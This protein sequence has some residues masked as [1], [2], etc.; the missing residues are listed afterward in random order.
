MV[1]G[2]LSQIGDTATK[3]IEKT[4]SLPDDLKYH[5][6]GAVMASHLIGS[7]GQFLGNFMTQCVVYDALLGRKYTLDDLKNS[8]DIW[9]LATENPSPARCFTYKAPGKG[10]T[11]QIMT[12]RQGAALL[13]PLL[14]Q[15]VENAFQLFEGTLLGK[16]REETTLP[17]IQLKR[18]LPIALGTM[19]GMAGTA[20]SAMLQQM[21]IPSVTGAIRDRA[22]EFAVNRGSLQQRATQETL[23]GVA[24]QKLIAMKNVL[25][26]LIY[27]AFIFILPMAMLPLGW[28]FIRTWVSL[29][30]WIQLWPPLYAIL[31]FI[32]TLAAQ[33]KSTALVQ[34]A[35]GI[36]QSDGSTGRTTTPEGHLVNVSNSQLRS[37]LQLS[38]SLSQNDRQQASKA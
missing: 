7:M 9:K 23:A 34:T 8:S 24:A 31:N 13:T 1:A 3:E 26:A 19:T 21:L 32:M 25:E 30:M 10:E 14:R 29:V 2:T 18:Y 33:S 27:V 38:E 15:D 5:K 11:P 35:G 4:F 20:E 28:S 12:C 6:T 17:G 22:Q 16:R 37:N 36:T